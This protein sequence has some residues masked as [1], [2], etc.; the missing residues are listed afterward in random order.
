[1]IDAKQP[2]EPFGAWY[3]FDPDGKPLCRVEPVGSYANTRVPC[4]GS[5]NPWYKP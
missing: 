3:V 4:M 2:C 5:P 1:M